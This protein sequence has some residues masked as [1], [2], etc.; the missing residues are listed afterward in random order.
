MTGWTSPMVA[1]HE[2]LDDDICSISSP[3]VRSSTIATRPS[4]L[5]PHPSN[6]G[7]QNPSYLVSPRNSAILRFITGPAA[8]GPW[9]SSRR[10]PS[11]RG[12]VLPPSLNVDQRKCP[13]A[14]NRTVCGRLRRD[15]DNLRWKH[16]LGEP[17]GLPRFPL[18]S[19][20]LA[21]RKKV[22]R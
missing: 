14:R 12:R 16:G 21:P 13:F 6:P 18:M 11:H 10:E 22:T 2:K 3:G 17:V 5:V 4:A 9:Q 7:F 8:A 15:A 19:G 1:A 20:K